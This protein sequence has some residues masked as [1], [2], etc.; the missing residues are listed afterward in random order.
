MSE[1]TPGQLNRATLARQLLLR[2]EALGVGEAV[3]RLVALQAQHPASPYLALWNRVDGFE[4]AALDEAYRDGTVVRSISV[5]ITL[6]T[7][8][9]DD[10]ATFHS[11]MQPSLRGSRLHDER[12]TSTGLT[13]ADADA[14]LPALLAHA[15][16]PRTSAEMEAWL[17]EHVRDASPRLWWAL[18]TYGPFA[19]APQPDAVWCFGQRNVFVAAAPGYRRDP[20]RSDADLVVLARRY[21]EGFGPASAA[22]L[23]QF[24]L[25]PRARARTALAALAGELDR[26]TGPDGVELF[27]VPGGIRPDADTPAPPRLLGMWEEIL[28]AYSDRSRLIPARHR[29]LVTRVNGDVLP[30]L[31]VDGH[32]AGVWRA[33]EGRIEATAFEP[34]PDEVWQAL[35]A[36]ARALTRFLAD[37]EPDVYRRHHHWWEKPLPGETRVLA[38]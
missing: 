8:H 21:L 7:V 36:E 14:A 3:R 34:L 11:A 18:R 29:K 22:D 35:A 19:H 25:V 12:F 26:F 10:H 38:G 4:A 20:E 16:E 9:R 30:T 15:A 13:A 31:L 23:A 33:T 32:V 27:D 37:R 24:A 2:R 1:L 5:R 17:T 28:L 6:H